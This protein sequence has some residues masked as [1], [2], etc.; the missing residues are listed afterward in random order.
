MLA[1]SVLG[2]WPGWKAVLE[3]LGESRNEKHLEPAQSDRPVLPG[4][5][6]CHYSCSYLIAVSLT[7]KNA[8]G[9]FCLSKFFEIAYL[10]SHHPMALVKPFGAIVRPE[11]MQPDT[12]SICA[13]GRTFI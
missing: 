8:A 5:N 3:R 1:Y 13:A 10:P 4:L 2:L 6:R 9:R 11:P 12:V 7:H